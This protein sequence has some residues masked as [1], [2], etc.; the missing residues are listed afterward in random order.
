MN[1]IQL[2]IDGIEDEG[3]Q[4]LLPA[5][6]VLLPTWAAPQA[7]ALWQDM[8]QIRRGAP[9]RSLTTPGGRPMSV[10]ITNCGDFGWFSDAHGYRYEATDPQTGQPWPAMPERFFRLAT[11]AA[12]AAGFLGFIP[13]SCLINR[14]APG[15][16]MTLHQDV[17]ERDLGSPVVYV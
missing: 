3:S 9:F 12:E 8:E 13:D 11:A 10:M 7:A 16:Q 15:A 2:T 5:G 4:P 6:V 1:G 14:Y 17:Q